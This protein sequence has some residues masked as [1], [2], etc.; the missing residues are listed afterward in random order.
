MGMGAAVAADAGRRARQLARAI[1]A[2]PFGGP[3]GV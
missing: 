1:R 3:A 2:R